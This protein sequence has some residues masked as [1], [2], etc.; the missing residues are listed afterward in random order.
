MKVAVVGLG[1]IGLPLAVQFAGR[2]HHTVGV[3]IDES[4]IRAVEEARPPFPNEADLAERLA[5]VVADGFLEA[6]SPEGEVVGDHRFAQILLRLASLDTESL[7]R[8]VVADVERFA[9]GKLDDDLTMLI[10]EFLGA[11]VEE[12]SEKGLQQQWHSRR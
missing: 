12:A 6:K 8:E 10:V 4:V 9:A 11:P 7:I 1:K 2:G 3:D 5:K